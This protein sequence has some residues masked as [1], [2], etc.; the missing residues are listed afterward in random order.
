MTFNAARA[1]GISGGQ[2]RA[3]YFD[4]LANHFERF[5]PFVVKT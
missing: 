4:Q 2:D 5:R 3:V 1:F